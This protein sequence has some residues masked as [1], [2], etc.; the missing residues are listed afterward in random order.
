MPW[1]NDSWA[2]QRW[3]FVCAVAS[4]RNHFTAV[5]RRF[6]I[7]RQTGYKWWRRFRT[8]GGAGLR[9]RS[10]RPHRRRTPW[11]KWWPRLRRWRQRHPQW[12]ARKLRWALRVAWPHQ[13][14]P[15]VRTLHRWL[16]AAGLVRTPRQRVRPARLVARRPNDVWTVDFKGRFQ[17]LDGTRIEPLTVRDLASRYGL[18]IRVLAA[19]D[20]P[21]VRRVLHALFRRHGLPRAIRVD[22]G[23]PFGGQGPRGLTRLSA[24]W[25]RLG[26]RV[27]FGRPACPQDNAAHEQWHGVLAA[28]TARPAAPTRVAQQRRFDRW[29]RDYNEQ[30]P[31]EALGMRVPAAVYRPSRRRLRRLRASRYPRGWPVLRIDAKGRAWWGGRARVIGRAFAGLCIG[32]KP[33][34]GGRWQAFLDA[35]FLGLM[36]ADDRAGLRPV[37]WRAAL[38]QNFTSPSS[39]RPRRLYSRARR[40]C[41]PCRVASSRGRWRSGTAR[42][43]SCRFRRRPR[44]G[45]CSCNPSPPRAPA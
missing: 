16:A 29:L 13:R 18:A 26:L 39:R 15:A 28:E 40:R 12:G 45:S 21:H 41:R 23:P 19:T 44:S 20:E 43:S 32:L 38:R 9:E 6:Q 33:A 30:R 35:H 11:R 8:A 3:Q 17:T 22:N 7:S 27:E 10:R 5:C 34:G 2:Q 37:Q 4:G 42:T 14:V 25:L 36:V 1:K 24:W 31:H